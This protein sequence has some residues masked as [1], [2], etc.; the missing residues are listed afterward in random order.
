[1]RQLSGSCLCGAIVLRLP[2]AFDYMGHCHCGECRKFSGADYATVGGLDADKVEL[3]Q[4]EEALT[5]YQKSP[6]TRLAFCR[7]CGA[8]LYSLKQ[9]SGKLNLRL[10][11]LDTAPSMRPGFHLFVGSKAP[12]HEIR[13]DLPQFATRP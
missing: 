2:D 10:G 1:M 9:S 5:L 7:H 11:C 12:W 13:D 6:E 3:V 8:T 4:G